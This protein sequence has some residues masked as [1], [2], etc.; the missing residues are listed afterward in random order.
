[1]TKIQDSHQEQTTQIYDTN[2]QKYKDGTKDFQFPDNMF[3]QFTSYLSGSAKVLDIWCAYGRDIEKLRASWYDASGI[4]IS[5]WLINIAE[6]K[7]KAYILQWDMT[8]L[9]EIYSPQSFDAVMSSASIVHLDHEIGLNVLQQIYNILKQ[10]GF[11]YLSLKVDTENRREYKESISTPGCVK[12]YVYYG[13]NE[14]E[15]ILVDLWFTILQTHIWTPNTDSWKI[16]I[17]QK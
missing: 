12:K 16:L 3:E 11:F 15:N 4:E 17:L 5:Q 1:M 13:E 14:I 8:Q 9:E 7:V 10:K 2:A 6:E